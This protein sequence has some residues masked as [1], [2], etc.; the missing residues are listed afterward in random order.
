[1]GYSPW[2]RKES[3][4]TQQLTQH[5]ACPGFCNG[6]SA[7]SELILRTKGHLMEEKENNRIAHHTLLAELQQKEAVTVIRD[8]SSVSALTH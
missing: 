6:S 3:D 2:G 7:P 8:G 4:T 1:M 5:I